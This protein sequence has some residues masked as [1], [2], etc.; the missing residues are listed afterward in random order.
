MR[1]FDFNFNDV[2]LNFGLVDCLSNA[3][4]Y[5]YG[6]MVFKKI[7]SKAKLIL[8][9]TLLLNFLIIYKLL[10]LVNFYWRNWMIGKM[11]K[12]LIFNRLL[13]RLYFKDNIK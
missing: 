13:N 2:A 5:T 10:Y 9:G 8:K 3:W 7:G 4:F 1:D 12:Y 11:R 6:Y